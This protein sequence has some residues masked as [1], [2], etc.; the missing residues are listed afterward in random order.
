MHHVM[1]GLVRD[2]PGHDAE[3]DGR[4]VKARVD[5]RH[6]AA[7]MQRQAAGVPQASRS[8][9]HDRLARGGG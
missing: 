4:V 5:G 8:Q 7:M 9:I 6:G 1:A 2:E 3:G